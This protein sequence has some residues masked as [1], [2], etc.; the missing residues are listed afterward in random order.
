M[1]GTPASPKTRQLAAIRKSPGYKQLELLFSLRA[2]ELYSRVKVVGDPPVMNGFRTTIHQRYV[3]NYCGTV[4]CHGN[5]DTQKLPLFRLQPNREA[6]VYTNFLTLQSTTAGGQ[7]VINRQKPENSLLL[8]YALTPSQSATPHPAVPGWQPRFQSKQDEF[9]QSIVR[10]IGSLW[11]P[12]P[13]YGIVRSSSET[14]TESE[15]Q[16]P[17][18]FP[19]KNEN[20]DEETSLD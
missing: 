12:T 13:D 9:Y 19:R 11:K 7:D 15:P 2:R 10:W 18:L 4:T 20:K 17:P 1:K 5:P 3:L 16:E 6:T 14:E 8:Q